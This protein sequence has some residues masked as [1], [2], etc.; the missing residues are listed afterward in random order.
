VSSD[1]V[2]LAT[3]GRGDNQWDS[4]LVGLE[5]MVHSLANSI[6]SA[7]HAKRHSKMSQDS[8]S[9]FISW[10]LSLVYNKAMFRDKMIV[11]PRMRRAAQN[12]L[13]E[14]IKMKGINNKYQSLYS[15]EAT[16]LLQPS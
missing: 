3:C 6:S 16:D 9:K 7:L 11:T 8:F 14:M 10:K 5:A 15:Q 4:S 13:N 2:N 1:Q 12:V